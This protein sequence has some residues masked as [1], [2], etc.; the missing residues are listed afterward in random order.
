M[1][2]DSSLRIN[3]SQKLRNFSCEFVP[4]DFCA[5]VVVSCYHQDC[6]VLSTVHYMQKCDFS[7]K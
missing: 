2:V 4:L 1:P 6:V 5:I 3:C 7:C